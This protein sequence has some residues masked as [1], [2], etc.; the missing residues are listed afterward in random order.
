MLKNKVRARASKEM[1]AMKANQRIL[2]RR[3]SQENE[4][5]RVLKEEWDLHNKSSHDLSLRKR[6]RQKNEERA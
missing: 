5:H 1:I 3:Q 6:S 2:Q 4:S